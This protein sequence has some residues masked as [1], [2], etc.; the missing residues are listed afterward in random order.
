M[1]QEGHVVQ[2]S[3]LALG[4]SIA[5]DLRRDLSAL[6]RPDDEKIEGPVARVRAQRRRSHVHV[7]LEGDRTF[8]DPVQHVRGDEARHRDGRDEDHRQGDS[9]ESEESRERTGRRKIRVARD[10][11]ALR[12]VEGP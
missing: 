8:A 9:E 2:G 4:A 7:V 11:R 10:R 12:V 5:E 3:L 1:D 6:V